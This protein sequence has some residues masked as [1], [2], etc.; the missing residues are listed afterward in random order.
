MSVPLGEVF[1]F[2]QNNAYDPKDHGNRLAAR[3][4]M[5]SCASKLSTYLRGKYSSNQLRV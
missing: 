2:A 5:R 1:S 4:E 3:Y